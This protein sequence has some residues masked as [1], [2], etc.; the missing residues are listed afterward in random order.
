GGSVA[1]VRVLSC[2]EEL[3]IALGGDRAL[4]QLALVG[5]QKLQT[6]LAALLA[7]RM[8]LIERVGLLDLLLLLRRC[9]AHADGRD[10]GRD[11]DAAGKESTARH[12]GLFSGHSLFRHRRV[13][14]GDNARPL[15]TTRTLDITWRPATP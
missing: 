5:R 7:A 10:A 8:V 4:D 9:R 13:R 2:R 15:Y 6:D 12:P 3:A 14:P 1:S 11:A